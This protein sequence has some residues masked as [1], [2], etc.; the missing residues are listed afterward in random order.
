MPDLN[1]ATRGR[2][3]YGGDYNPEQWP[4]SVW[5][6]D[7]RLMRRA[8]VTAVTVGV[9]SWA[10]LEPRPG[11]RDFGWL[12][13][14]LDLLHEGGIEVCLATPTASPPPWMGSR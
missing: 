4:E 13:R 7:I 2:V 9:F 1:D 11:A 5:H 10:R 6:D 8:G 14:V 12:D 3:L